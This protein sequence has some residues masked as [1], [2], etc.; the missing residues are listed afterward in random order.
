MRFLIDAS[1]PRQ[2]AQILAEMGHQ[3]VDVRD[4]GL[5]AA[6]DEVIAA[7]AASEGLCILTRDHDFG[8]VR[9]YPPGDYPGIV[10]FD[11]PDQLKVTF[12]LELLR[13]FAANELIISQLPGRLAVVDPWRTRLR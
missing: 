7:Y 5:G 6:A 8:D 12:F 1:L 10:V 13:T 2:V 9:N 11:V 4:M 3:T